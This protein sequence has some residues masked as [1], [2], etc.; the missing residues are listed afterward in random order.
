[1]PTPAAAPKLPPTAT[2][3]VILPEVVMAMVYLVLV[4]LWSIWAFATFRYAP[5]GEEGRLFLPDLEF[6]LV[7]GCNV[8]FAALFVLA[9]RRSRQSSPAL[10]RGHFAGLVLAAI[11]VA[12]L[13]YAAILAH[14]TEGIIV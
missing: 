9:A 1:M 3:F 10:R 13:Q 14:G 12:L 4:R 5:L 2:S 6:A 7:T 8:V 11:C